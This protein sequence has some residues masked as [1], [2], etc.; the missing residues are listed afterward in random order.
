MMACASCNIFNSKNI[1]R[2]EVSNKQRNDE[3]SKRKQLQAAAFLKQ[4]KITKLFDFEAVKM[5]LK[6]KKIL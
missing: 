4:K 2:E 3:H 6:N 1:A 5:D